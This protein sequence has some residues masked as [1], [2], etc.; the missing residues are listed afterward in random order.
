MKTVIENLYSTFRKYTTDGIHHCD[1]GCINEEDVIKL[2][3]KTLRDLEEN[4]F[5][6]GNTKELHCRLSN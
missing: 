4:D 5:S 6:D 2:K 3:S 1:C